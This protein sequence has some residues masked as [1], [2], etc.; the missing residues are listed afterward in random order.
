MAMTPSVETPVVGEPVVAA[1][2]AV[3][4]D[5]PVE[6]VTPPTE[7]TETVEEP[8]ADEGET[9]L[10]VPPTLEAAG[11]PSHYVLFPAGVHWDWYE[12]CR[13]YFERFRPSWG[14]NPHDA[15]RAE[16]ITCINPDQE[17]L[18]TLNRLNPSAYL[19]VIHASG[20]AELSARVGKRILRGKAYGGE[21]IR[22]PAPS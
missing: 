9:V 22:N 18:D 8:Q 21:S 10:A 19:E 11:A 2:V 16:V 3:A 6:S 4:V 17:T 13:F 5:V 1:E 7:T 15:A 12:A 20:P 14:E